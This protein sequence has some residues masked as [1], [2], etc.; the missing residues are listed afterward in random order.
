MWVCV[1]DGGEVRPG[2]EGGAAGSGVK[3]ES[4]GSECEM[5]TDKER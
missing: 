4:S 5:S 2:D 3:P 1:C